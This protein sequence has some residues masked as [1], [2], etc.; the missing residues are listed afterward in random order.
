MKDFFDIWLLARHF[1]FSGADLA[2]A[3]R[4]TFRNRH[5]EID[6][7]PVALTATF[8]AS[9]TTQK[10][11]DAFVTRS[12]IEAAPRTLD[13]IREHLREFQM[14]VATAL[15]EGRD[16]KSPGLKREK[17]QKTD[18]AW[19]FRARSPAENMTS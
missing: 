5:T 15:A 1:D 9:E 2:R 17:R 3:I 7:D 10:Q 8:T 13:A 4:R 14:P 19:E 16:F 6:S 11:W 12:R 18:K